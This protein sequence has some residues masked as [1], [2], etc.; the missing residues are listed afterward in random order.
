MNSFAGTL[1]PLMRVWMFPPLLTDIDF[2]TGR[3]TDA[4]C[5]A[6]FIKSYTSAECFTADWVGR[7]TC[8]ST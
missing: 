7:I 1:M 6:G 4:G 2:M 5:L 3:H 8:R